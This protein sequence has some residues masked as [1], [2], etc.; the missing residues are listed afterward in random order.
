MDKMKAIAMFAI[1][2]LTLTGWAVTLRR[3][4]FVNIYVVLSM[5]MLLLYGAHYVRLLVPLMPFLVL[6]FLSGV[7]W[8]V[9]RLS[10]RRLVRHLLIGAVGLALIFD[11]VNALVH[12]PRQS[13][14]ARFGNESFQSCLKWAESEIGPGA[15]VVCQLHSYLFLRRGPSAVPFRQTATAAS[16]MNYLDTVGANYLI[17]SPYYHESGTDYMKTVREALDSNA[18]LFTRVFS[19]ADGLSYILHYEPKP[20][21]P[22]PLRQRAPYRTDPGQ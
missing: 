18:H 9:Q 21:P 20:S 16:F 11:N 3:W 13:M 6:Y 7:Q 1:S 22:A 15:V 12:A 17:I 8:L 10:Q 19:A 5:G 14:P 2:L 4:I